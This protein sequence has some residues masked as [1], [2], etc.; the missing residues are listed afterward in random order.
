[1]TATIERH[2]TTRVLRVH[3]P[4]ARNALDSATI[5]TL[6]SLVNDLDHEARAI[7]LATHGPTFIAGGDL[8]EFGALEG[9]AGGRAV[10]SKG[11]RLVRALIAT[12]LPLVAAV[13]GD[14][15]GG[16]CE[17]AAHCDVRFA[18][19]TSRFHWVQNRLAVTT[20]W[21][22]THRLV[23]IV[24]PATSA[25]WLLAA[26]SVSAEEAFRAGFVDQIAHE[27]SALELALAWCERLATIDP[28][29]TR[30]QLALIRDECASQR[31]Q[32]QQ[33]EQRAFA[34]SWALP[35]HK[36]AVARFLTGRGSRAQR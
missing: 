35:A 24:G 19:A 26:E 9:R 7:V 15:Y 18:H 23:Q 2:G 8:K 14:A 13:D 17:L 16:G 25:R 5:D 12:G 34:E 28:T 10:A 22:A 6:V 36:E 32:A 29:V 27:G 33:R 11:R 20:G 30:L 1:M 31:R 3:R 21:G 4:H